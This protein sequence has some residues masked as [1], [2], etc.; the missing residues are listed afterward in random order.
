MCGGPVPAAGG[1]GRPRAY[2]SDRCRWRA[3]RQRARQ[4][5]IEAA[6]ARRAAT[7]APA[8]PWDG[9][10]QGIWTVDEFA[11][12]LEANGLLMTAEDFAAVV[13]EVSAPP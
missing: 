4:R 13:A 6:R 9:T 1:R 3:S 12:W 8:Q 2:C 10:W 11:A 7:V 5:A